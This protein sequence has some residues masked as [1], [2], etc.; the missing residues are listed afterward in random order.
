MIVCTTTANKKFLLDRARHVV[1]YQGFDYYATATGN[2]V[3][4]NKDGTWTEIEK[5]VAQQHILLMPYPIALE[6]FPEWFA[7]N[8]ETI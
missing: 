3:R 6:L 1:N 8:P 4:D 7:A 2:I 5:A